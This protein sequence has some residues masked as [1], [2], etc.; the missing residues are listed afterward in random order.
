M[1]VI[2]RF[3]GGI[4]VL[5]EVSN[6]KITEI[7]RS[8]L[9]ENAGEGD[10]VNFQNGSYIINKEKTAERRRSIIARMRKMGL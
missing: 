8:L 1:I 6:G 10:V 5:E 4:A 2:E 7:D 9:P 3:E